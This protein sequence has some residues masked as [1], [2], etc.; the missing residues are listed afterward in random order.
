[1]S[2]DKKK[3][4]FYLQ[5]VDL[6]VFFRVI[7]WLDNDLLVRNK[8]QN[9]SCVS[10]CRRRPRSISANPRGAAAYL[11]VTQ[12]ESEEL[13]LTVGT[14]LTFLQLMCQQQ[15]AGMSHVLLFICPWTKKVFMP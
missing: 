5:T 6:I 8:E 10:L 15:R 4:N 9:L 11:N 2:A 1:M 13:F 7:R 12:Q 3:N 14:K